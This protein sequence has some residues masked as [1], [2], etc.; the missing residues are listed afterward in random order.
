[1]SQKIKG[2]LLFQAVALVSAMMLA[3][4]PAHAQATTCT[5]SQSSIIQVC[6]PDLV[7]FDSDSVQAYLAA[8]SLPATDSSIMFQYART[9]LRNQLR[10]F[11]FARLL[12]IVLRA[13]V[14]RT[15]HEQAVYNAFQSRVWQHQ[16]DQYQ[17][18]VNDRNSWE[19]NPCTWRPDAD[20]ANAYALNYDPAPFCVSQPFTTLFTAA[21]QTPSQSYFLAAALKNTFGK[22]LASTTGGAAIAADTGAKLLVVL[23]LAAS[24][25]TAAASGIGTALAFDSAG[26]APLSLFGVGAAA[27]VAA[28]TPATGPLGMVQLAMATTGLAALQ[29]FQGQPTLD[30]LAQLDSMNAAVQ[31]YAQDLDVFAANQPGLYALLA[32]F[33]EMTVPEFAS[34]TMLPSHRT[35]DLNFVIHLPYQIVT[36]EFAQ[37]AYTDW[38]GA[39]WTASTYGGWLVQTCTIGNCTQSASFSPTI[40][41]VDWSGTKWTASR[42]GANFLLTKQS[43]ASTDRACPAT[44]PTG[45]SNPSDPSKCSSLVASTLQLM[46]NHGRQVT[47]RLTQPPVFTSL[48]TATFTEGFPVPKTFAIAASGVPLPSITLAGGSLPSGI[49]FSSSA[50]TGTGTAAFTTSNSPPGPIP[51]NG[52]Y[53]VTLQAQNSAGTATQTFTVVLGRQFQITSPATA[54]F[55]YGQPGSFTI[56]TAGPPGLIHIDYDPRILPTGLSF[57]DNGDGTATI[58][59]TALDYPIAPACNPLGFGVGACGIT[60]AIDG[61]ASV[62][63]ALQIVV[64]YA[65]QPA[66]VSGNTATFIS[67]RPNSFLVAT[68]GAITPVDFHLPCSPPS[69]LNLQDNH[70]GT[71]ILGGVPPIDPSVPTGL[72]TI[73]RLFIFAHA[74]GSGVFWRPSTP[75]GQYP[76]NLT[77]SVI[78]V[79]MFTNPDSATFT[80]GQSGSAV[81]SSN[82]FFGNPLVSYTGVLPGGTSF[83]PQHSAGMVA[84]TPV[85]SGALPAGGAGGDYPL[86]FSALGLGGLMNLNADSWQLVSDTQPVTATQQFDLRVNQPPAVVS[87]TDVN[88]T[89]GVPN[90]FT[91]VT[92]GFPQLPDDGQPGMS[93][94]YTGTLPAGVTFSQVTPVGLST[95][96]FALSGTPAASPTGP[97]SIM[98]TANNGVGT[99]HQTFTVH[100]IKPGD[101]N[102]DGKVD[103]SDINVVK[104]AMGTYRDRIGYDYRADANND[105]VVNGLD[106]AYV[107]SYLPPGTVCQ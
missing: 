63:Q 48:S 84:G 90:T 30:Q 104:A 59:G 91:F 2:P 79:P 86:T 24:P 5:P 9:D 101:V 103:C 57:Q 39:N 43:P 18:A 85:L 60:A 95:G 93:I 81:L 8:H 62:F 33:T 32:T 28:G 37:L 67:G 66:I 31:A 56:T 105:G 44:A 77:L 68:G 106:L 102:A 27:S 83:T 15:S 20:V 51:P 12:D 29:P 99:A 76:P 71:A 14:Q 82:L 96:V 45:L 87:S 53:S 47:A 92:T 107:T 69:W 80:A 55:T 58:S 17:A 13:P 3:P 64:N 41:F 98:L 73:Y 49:V 7:Q 40:D 61:V 94:S 46:D 70:D 10:A 72:P 35:S 21:P 78:S 74:A 38:N 11:E 42:V 23:G 36:P 52:S 100:V 19:A 25:A 34:A 1:M 4:P 50:V 75:C 6:D 97:F 65:P 26:A 22:A 88:F 16:K 89:I 54:Q